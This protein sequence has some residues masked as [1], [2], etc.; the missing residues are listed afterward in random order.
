MK[1]TSC[2]VLT[3]ITKAATSGIVSSRRA[4]YRAFSVNTCT[5]CSVLNG[6]RLAYG[7]GKMWGV[8]YSKRTYIVENGWHGFTTERST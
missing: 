5:P 4:I 3:Y 7:V 2:K 8:T 1:R 6:L